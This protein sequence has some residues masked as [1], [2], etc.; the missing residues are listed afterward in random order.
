MASL[1]VHEFGSQAELLLE[2]LDRI[3]TVA[4]DPTTDQLDCCRG[5]YGLKPEES[6]RSKR[7]E[8]T[9]LNSSAY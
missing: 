4:R 1:E 8:T 9:Q 5:R 2:D 7:R 3:E 6:H